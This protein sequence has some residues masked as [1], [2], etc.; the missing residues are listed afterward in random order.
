MPTFGWDYPI[1]VLFV[2]KEQR[3]DRI[4]STAETCIIDGCDF[5]IRGVLEIGVRGYSTPFMWGLWASVAEPD[6]ARYIAGLRAG[7]LEFDAPIAGDLHSVPSIYPD[8]EHLACTLEVR[9]VGKRPLI[10]VSDLDH[11]LGRDQRRGFEPID[12]Q[13]IAESLLHPD[14]FEQ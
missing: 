10:H 3:A 11:P 2:P 1:D 9:P 7:V 12:V 8:T 5:F 13:R 6:F 14:A 4:H